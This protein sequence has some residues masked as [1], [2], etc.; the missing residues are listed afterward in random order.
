MYDTAIIGSGPAGLSA[1]LNLKLHEKDVIWFGAKDL[2]VKVEKSE[3]IANYP[4][5][6]M[7]SGADLNRKFHEQ[8]EQMDL[9]LTDAMVTNI[10]PMDGSFQLLA[11]NEIYEA[12]TL[13]LAIGAVAAK[14]FAGEQDFL[15]R[16]VSYCATCDG[17]L[18]KG[19]TIAVY[20][21]DRHFEHEAEYLAGLARKVY[22]YTPYADCG[23][24]LPNVERLTRPLKEVIGG[25]KVTAI[26]LTDGTEL[27]ADG[28]F[29]L[30]NAV[31][32]AVLLP[33]LSMDGP[34]IAVNRRAETNLPG[35]YAAGDCTG[36]PYQI[37][38][39]AG[40]GNVAAHSILE[41]L[42]SDGKK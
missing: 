4:G 8:M 16:G 29:C 32:P 3:K 19:K 7:V 13:L 10:L 17:F 5:I 26:R 12:R 34:H 11:E 41:Y 31:A 30:R 40:E 36:R 23:V 22:L 20:C 37:A 35:C 1:A 38:K 39:A 6:P 9:S 33:G 42:S 2:S 15:G 28:L 25:M 18:Y 14:G 27:A 21:Q 24:D